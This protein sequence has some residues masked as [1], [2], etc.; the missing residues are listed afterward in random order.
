V[1]T[2]KVW[3]VRLGHIFDQKGLALHHRLLEESELRAALDAWR[4]GPSGDLSELLV[5]HGA[6]ARMSQ[7]A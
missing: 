3:E 6:L 2:S 7:W 5:S 1:S 4:A